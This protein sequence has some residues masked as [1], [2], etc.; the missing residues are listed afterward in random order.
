LKDYHAA[1]RGRDAAFL[2][3]CHSNNP[4]N[5]V[6]GVDHDRH[7]IT[8]RAWDF[9]VDKQVLQLAVPQASKEAPA[10]TTNTSLEFQQ[11][12]PRSQN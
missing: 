7:A 3:N 4:H 9:P 1:F 12:P 6:L 11:L 10:N 5:S 2:S 8:F